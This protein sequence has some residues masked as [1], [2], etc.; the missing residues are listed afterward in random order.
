MNEQHFKTLMSTLPSMAAVV[1]AFDS[2]EVQMQAY[3]TLMSALKAKTQGRH[4]Q[5]GKPGSNGE[6]MSPTDSSDD[7]ELAHNL[8]DGDSIHEFTGT[9]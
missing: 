5:N 3:N 6:K 2:P 8:V 9:N 7:G 1:N 4:S